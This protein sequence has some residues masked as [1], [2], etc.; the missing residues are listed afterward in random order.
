MHYTW[1]YCKAIGKAGADER[2]RTAVISLEGMG[3]LGPYQALSDKWALKDPLERKRLISAVRTTEAAPNCCSRVN[4]QTELDHALWQSL[5]PRLSA[6]PSVAGHSR[7]AYRAEPWKTG[8]RGNKPDGTGSRGPG[9]HGDLGPAQNEA[10]QISR[11][12][13]R[14]AKGDAPRTKGSFGNEP[15]TLPHEEQDGTRRL[16]DRQHVPAARHH[17]VRAR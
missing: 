12:R 5:I 16:S 9:Q 6:L 11:S 3:P 15:R 1:C 7:P 17:E 13:R 2:N 8:P 4:A 14:Q 10:H